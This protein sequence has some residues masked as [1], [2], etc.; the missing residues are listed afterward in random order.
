VIKTTN[1]GGLFNQLQPLWDTPMNLMPIM[2]SLPVIKGGMVSPVRQQP[3]LVWIVLR[4][5][6][7]KFKKPIDFINNM[8]AV[9]ECLLD[10]NRHL[11]GDDEAANGQEHAADPL[12]LI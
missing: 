8:R 3:D 6:N 4:T 5:E 11:V 10:L 9:A 1:P 12:S 7:V 2:T